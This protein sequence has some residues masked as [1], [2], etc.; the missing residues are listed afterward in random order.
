MPTLF[1]LNQQQMND[2]LLYTLPQW[3]IFAAV[4]VAVYGW[5]EKKK[6][7][8]IIGAAIF[9]ILGIYSIIIISGG[10]L[11]GGE[12]LTLGEIAD[13]ELDGEVVEE[14]PFQAKLLPAYLSFIGSAI[15][16]I[17][18]IFFDLK[19]KKSYQWFIIASGLVALFGFFVIVGVLQYL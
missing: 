12:F 7:F 4:F 16:A 3:F 18:A 10:Y 6:A 17:P 5:I 8:R 13:K 2:T 19:N 1:T 11:A 15:I 9:I 14:I